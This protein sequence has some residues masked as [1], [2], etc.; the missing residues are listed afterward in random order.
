MT[1]PEGQQLKNR[2]AR[3]P[4]ALLRAPL[5][6]APIRKHAD[7][8]RE[9]S[10]DELRTLQGRDREGGGKMDGVKS[11]SADPSSKDVVIDFDEPATWEAIKAT[12]VKHD[13]PPVE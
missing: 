4:E 9:G 8:D 10:G 3:P 1:L 13:F 2:E 6:A 11:V 12:L 7:H 5:H